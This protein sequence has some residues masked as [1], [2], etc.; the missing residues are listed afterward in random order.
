MRK[1]SVKRVDI[2]SLLLLT[3][4]SAVVGQD[5]PLQ[6]FVIA[7]IAT[8]HSTILGEDRSLFIYNPDK[9]GANLLPSYPVLY[10]LDEN[11]MTLVTGLVKYLSAYNEQMS[12]LIVVGIGGGA[13][14]IRDLTPT[15]SLIDNL[16]QLD[17]SPDS[18]LKDSG[19]SER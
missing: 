9:N 17:S 10:T 1:K 14:R 13:T 3:L 19:G 5:Q 6:P 15:H 4:P 8:I 18:W 11:D 7:E 12:P 2:V 16:G